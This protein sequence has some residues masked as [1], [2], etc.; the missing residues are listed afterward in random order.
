MKKYIIAILIACGLSSSTH[1]VDP[2]EL[3]YEKL[4]LK[5]GTHIYVYHNHECRRKQPFFTSTVEKIN[6]HKSKCDV[7][8]ICIGEEEA[9]MLNV[10]S[11]YNIRKDIDMAETYS[12]FE[13]LRKMNL[14]Y[15]TSN[16]VYD[17]YYSVTDN[18]KFIKLDKPIAG[19]ILLDEKEGRK[20]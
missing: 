16:R 17:V 10:I 4:E 13:D 9:F 11:N 1:S 18:G 5:D 8:D 20:F 14:R 2:E 6:Y 19:F 7:Y 3:W 15:D 12:E